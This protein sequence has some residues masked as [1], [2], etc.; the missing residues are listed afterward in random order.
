MS[1]N[2]PLLAIGLF[3]GG[4]LSVSAA[5]GIAFQDSVDMEFTFNPTLSLS[6]S[7]DNLTIDNLTPGNFKNSNYID[8]EVVTNSV[9]GYVLSAAVG[10]EETYTNTDLIISP[11]IQNVF[12]SITNNTSSITEDNTWGYTIDDGNTYSAL[13]YKGN[14]WTVLRNTYTHTGDNTMSFAIGAKAGNTQPAGDYKNIINFSVVANMSRTLDINDITYMQDFHL[15]N[16]DEMNQ[17]KESM[18]ENQQYT[19]KDS[20]DEKE[21]F[22]AKLADG[23]IWMTQNL[24][25]NITTEENF[26][27]SENTD[28]PK[29]ASPL[30][31]DTITYATDDAWSWV[32]IP[33]FYDPGD[34]CWDGILKDNSI[35]G[36]LNDSTI[37]CETP[38]INRHYSMGNYYNWIAAAA[39]NDSPSIDNM[40]GEDVNQS[41]CPAGWRLPTYS[42]D[43]SYQ[44]LVTSLSLT[45]GGQGNIQN[46]PVYFV[47][48][49]SRAIA[50]PTLR[51]VGRIGVY[52]TDI[53]FKDSSSKMIAFSNQDEGYIYDRSVDMA[54]GYSV[55]CV[56]R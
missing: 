25:H 16:D 7:S 3:L 34:F 29:S 54:S 55:R 56:A 46:F 41:I 1:T 43:K 24:D 21:Y 11:S 32:Y 39:M 53:A 28:I 26:Y 14:N 19:L 20:R 51:G 45:A 37:S 9:A 18:T 13:P 4:V 48:G 6:L 23:N 47:Y 30:T 38:S 50:I 8:I 44:N 52:W 42:G 12:S 36:T 15:F 40:Q 49:G 2:K 31:M 35:G 22:I 5:K 33:Q 10:D 17:V 27:T